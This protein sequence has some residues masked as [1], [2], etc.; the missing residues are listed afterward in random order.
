MKIK[1]PLKKFICQKCT[2]VMEQ[3]MHTCTTTCLIN[4]KL[5]PRFLDNPTSG[6]LK[7]TLDCGMLSDSFKT[8]QNC[9]DISVIDAL[10]GTKP[11]V[12]KKSPVRCL[13]PK[14][15]TKVFQRNLFRP[16]PPPPP[17]TVDVSLNQ[18]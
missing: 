17:P 18:H 1:M 7:F 12:F 14:L 8:A 6:H 2:R 3:I 11:G 13:R 16:P 5:G 4:D 15:Q 10:C 9:C